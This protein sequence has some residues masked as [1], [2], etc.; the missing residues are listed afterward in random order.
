LAGLRRLV[1]T[2]PA[3]CTGR[4]GIVPTVPWRASARW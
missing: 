4:L 3:V 2:R 1:M